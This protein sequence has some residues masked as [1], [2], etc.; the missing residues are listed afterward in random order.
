MTSSNHEPWIYKG[1]ALQEMPEGYEGFV[2]RI[3][4]PDGRL[5][6][7]QK[8][9]TFRRT[10]TLKGKRVRRVVESDWR[11]YFGSSDEI[12]DLVK[13]NGSA[14]FKREILYLCQT[15][16]AMNY[17]E[18]L[19]ILSSGA[20]LSD[21]YVNKWVSVKINKGTVLGKISHLEALP[22]V[23]LSEQPAKP[24]RKPKNVANG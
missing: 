22:D 18:C 20:L 11:D 23:D 12:K 1:V 8:K 2:Y 19:L 16:S 10:K 4:L 3:T 6:I 14:G 24:K 9:N 21:R 15:K 17:I 5:Y 13:A 7:G